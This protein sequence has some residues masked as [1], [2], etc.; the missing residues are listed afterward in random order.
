MEIS[1]LRPGMRSVDVMFKV[2]NKGETRSTWSGKNVADALVGDKTGCILMTL[3]EKQIDRVDVGKSYT[4][5]EGFTNLFR[6]SLRLNIGRYGTI[7]E[8]SE[9]VGEV[10]EGNNLSEKEYPQER[11]GFGRRR[12]SY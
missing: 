11:R 6:G 12:R 8:A 9:E 10:N 3:W 7:E 1:E 2:I 5:K 4:L